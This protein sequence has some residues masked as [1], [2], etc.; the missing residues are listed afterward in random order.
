MGLLD[1][2][3]KDRHKDWI[4]LSHSNV[5]AFTRGFTTEELRDAVFNIDVE[6]TLTLQP[7]V[8]PEKGCVCVYYEKN[9]KTKK[10]CFHAAFEDPDGYTSYISENMPPEEAYRIMSAYLDL[11]IDPETEGWTVE[12]HL[13]NMEPAT[14]IQFVMMFTGD[15]DILA[16]MEDCS[17]APLNYLK[18]HKEIIPPDDTDE[19]YAENTYNRILNEGPTKAN[20]EYILLNAFA[21]EM[22]TAG[23]MTRV[24]ETPDIDEFAAAVEPFARKFN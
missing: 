8:L 21:Y 19:N 23:I 18:N 20:T 17:A 7:C 9:E 6:K 4:L 5:L 14:F 12:K 2:L 16:R 1:F 15:K 24:T 13:K 22:Y 10:L 11:G 3:K